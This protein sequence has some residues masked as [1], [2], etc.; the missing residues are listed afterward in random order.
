[1]DPTTAIFGT[2]SAIALLVIGVL[3]AIGIAFSRGKAL[4]VAEA[5]L[6]AARADIA[7]GHATIERE[8]VAVAA[9]EA[10]REDTKRAVDGVA[11]L[12]DDAAVGLLFGG[13]PPD[14]TTTPSHA[15][16]PAPPGRAA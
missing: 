11:A 6:V 14:P 9:G 4:G 3:I 2:A 15:P 13:A 8:R 12:P 1:M 16:D 7:E 10:V 5:G